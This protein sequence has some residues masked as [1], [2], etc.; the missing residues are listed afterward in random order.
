TDGAAGEEAV[1]DYVLARV[2]ESK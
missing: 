2:G 1:Y